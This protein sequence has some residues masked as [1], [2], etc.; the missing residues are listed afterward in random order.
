[1]C[2][3]RRLCKN[4]ECEECFGRSFASNERSKCWNIEKN[5][6]ITQR[7]VF[8][9]SHIKYWFE[10]ACGHNFQMGLDSITAGRWCQYCSN[11]LLCENED[12]EMCKEKSFASNEEK[13]LYWSEKNIVRPRQVFK[14]AN[15]KY[16]FDCDTCCH[17]FEMGL[18]S[19]TA[20]QWCQYCSNKLL[21]ENEDCEM[22]KE[23]SFAS[24]EEKALY[25]SEK[26]IVQPR[27][28][29]KSSHTKKYFFDCEY[30]HQFQMNL[31]N[32]TNN[33]Q[34]CPFCVNKTETKLY[35]KVLSF[36]PTIVKGFRVDW[37]KNQ[38]TN[39]Y[40]PFDFVLEEQKV[41]IELDGQQHFK[42]VLNWSSPEEQLIN[43]KYKEKC[44]N[45]N[46]YFIIRILQLDVWNDKNDW[47]N[48]L[49]DAILK[50]NKTKNIY[51]CSNNEYKN[52]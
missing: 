37:C 41:I 10:C 3:P 32:I 16:L 4:E 36:F 49:K 18:N 44:A 20:G 43:D 5:G 48:R 22:C 25:W 52:F 51:L 11:K 2:N 34:W 30:G 13:A 38:S 40:L 50:E 42:Q 6:D 19:I 21:C 45:E 14:F 27:Q 33:N 7:D 24:N 26:N 39:R 15:T 12:C 8:K 23:K 31:G 29:F 47:L 17:Q 1:M 46:G 9:S 35:E 28:V